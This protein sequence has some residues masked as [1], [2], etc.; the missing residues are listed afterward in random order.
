MLRRFCGA[1]GDRLLKITTPLRSIIEERRDN[2]MA[3]AGLDKRL[4]SRHNK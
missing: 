3:L 4:V 1:K 2:A